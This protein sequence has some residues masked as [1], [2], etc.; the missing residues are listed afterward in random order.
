MSK[1][2]PRNQNG[3]RRRQLRARVLAEET[4]CWLCHQPVDKTLP[5]RHDRA[6]EVHELIPV[7]RGGSPY[8]R[9]NTTLT[10]RECN[11]WISN[12]TP[13]ELQHQRTG[14]DN[15]NERAHVTTAIAW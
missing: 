13:D 11:R 1:P 4:H 12:R 3:H 8:L 15:S 10:H 5:A 2:N 7:S 14:Q 6:P 9:D